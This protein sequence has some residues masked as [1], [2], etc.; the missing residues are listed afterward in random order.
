MTIGTFKVGRRGAG[1]I[2]NQRLYNSQ[3]LNMVSSFVCSQILPYNEKISCNRIKKSSTRCKLIICC[4][5]SIEM[6]IFQFGVFRAEEFPFEGLVG[7]VG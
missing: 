5:I 7:F 4:S 3:W 6:N 2:F 1:E